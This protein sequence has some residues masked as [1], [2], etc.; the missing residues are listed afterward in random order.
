MQEV[1]SPRSTFNVWWDP[2]AARIVFNTPWPRLVLVSGDAHEGIFGTRP[3]LD[4]ATASGKPV[5]RYVARIAQAGFPLWDEV[6]AA[7]WQNPAIVTRKVRL[8]MDIDLMP[9]PNY[10]A[11]VI[12]PAGKGPGLGEQDVEVVL[13]VDRPRMEA[14]FVDLLGR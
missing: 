8:A 11:I 5:A 12:W 7:A 9:G 4:R 1:Y 6:E 3:L 10:G 13:H 14:M 2:E